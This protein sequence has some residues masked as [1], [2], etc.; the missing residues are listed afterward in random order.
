MNNLI[1]E[2]KNDLIKSC[3]L[4]CEKCCRLKKIEELKKQLK[5]KDELLKNGI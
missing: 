4:E 2:I 1:Q 3:A 5:E